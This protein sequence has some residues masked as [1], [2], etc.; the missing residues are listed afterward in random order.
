M[1][2][3]IFRFLGIFTLGIAVLFLILLQGTRLYLLTSYTTLLYGYFI[4]LTAAA[5]FLS[6]EQEKKE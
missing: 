3:H 1:K 6:M 5:F 4:T 2:F